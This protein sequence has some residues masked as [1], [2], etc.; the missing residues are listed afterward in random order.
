MRVTGDHPPGVFLPVDP[1]NQLL[2]EK[3][4]LAVRD[5]IVSGLPQAD[6]GKSTMVHRRGQ[7]FA[8][9]MLG[10]TLPTAHHVSMERSRLAL[11][12]RLVV[13]VAD[14]AIGRFDTP[15]R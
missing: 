14:G 2:P 6:L 12:Q 11:E 7:S 1:G 13:G 3:Y 10:V 5:V 15:H 9:L 8:P 4:A